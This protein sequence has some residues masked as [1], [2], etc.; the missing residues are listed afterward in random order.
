MAFEAWPAPKLPIP[1][2]SLVRADPDCSHQR[3]QRLVQAAR[4]RQAVH[5]TGAVAGWRQRY[6]P[7][8]R[9]PL[10]ILPCRCHEGS[11]QLLASA[12][13]AICCAAWALLQD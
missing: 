6:R 5:G 13:V 4:T 2:S 8:G 3:D 9:G 11:T 7:D 10:C 1:Y 12:V